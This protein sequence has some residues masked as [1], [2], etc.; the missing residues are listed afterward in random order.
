MKATLEMHGKPTSKVEVTHIDKHGFWIFAEEKEYFLSFSEFPWFKSAKIS[1]INNLLFLH[2]HHLHW[3]DLDI[4]LE[5]D[6][7]KNPAKY[8]LKDIMK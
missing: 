6:C 1:E 3:P 5:L 4:D 7:I 2:G 8:P